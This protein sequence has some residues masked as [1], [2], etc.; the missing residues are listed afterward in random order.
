LR[1]AGELGKFWLRGGHQREGRAWLAAVL[2]LPEEGDTAAQAARVTALDAAAWLADDMHDFAQAAALFA[3]SDALRQALGQEGSTAG[4]LINAAMEAR[5]GGDYARA[6]ALLEDGLARV[7]AL[8]SGASG[9]PGSPAQVLSVANHYTLLAL[10]LREQGA[11]AR[12]SALYEEC[13]AVSRQLGDA[14]GIGVAL[15][16][17]ADLARDEGDAQRA[18]AYGAECLALFKELGHL[19]AIGFTLNNL[20]LAAYQEGHL[21][22][23]ADHAEESAALFRG[24]QADP[25][26]AEVLVTL[27]R[28]RAAQGAA[29]TAQAHLAEALRLAW[30]KGPRLVVAMAL[31]ELGA[32]AVGQSQARHGVELLGAAVALRAAIGAPVRPADWPALEGALAAA[33]AALGE[34]TYA[35]AWASGHTLPLEQSVALAVAGPHDEPAP[36]P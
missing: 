16:G 23:A 12:A 8:G 7:R 9:Q 26:L 20:A 32:L 4:L 15:L 10:V 6:T 3:Q 11:H 2:A 17:L 27:G 18:R 33:R 30:A 28:I 29:G 36:P 14:E 31:E 21:A 24:Q 19:W 25:S 5:A 35:D 1:L 13:L 22:Q 34:V